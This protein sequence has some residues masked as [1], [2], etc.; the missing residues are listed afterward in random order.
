MGLSW[1]DLRAIVT[2]TAFAVV[3]LVSF[4]VLACSDETAFVALS[5]Q[6]IVSG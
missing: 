3:L 6:K 2:T 4:W 1:G 5:S